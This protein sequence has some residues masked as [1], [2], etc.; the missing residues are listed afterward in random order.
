MLKTLAAIAILSIALS[1][2]CSNDKGSSENQNSSIVTESQDEANLEGQPPGEEKG[3][4]SGA[5]LTLGKS[6]DRVQNGV[7]LLMS[8]DVRSNSFTGSLENTT[9]NTIEKVRVK[10]H[11][12]NDLDLGP[13]NPVDLKPG[14]KRFIQLMPPGKDFDGW[15]AGVQVGGDG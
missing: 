9:E 6:Y 2:G 5:E 1:Y 15:T 12:S 10:I 3:E 13:T 11:L 14:Q 4:E 7:R 8:F